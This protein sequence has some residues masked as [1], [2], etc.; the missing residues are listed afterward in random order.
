MGGFIDVEQAGGGSNRGY[1]AEAADAGAPGVVVIQEW[2]GL[3]DQI[4]GT[5]DR[6]AA[7]GYNALAPD[8]YGGE[9]AAYH[10][11]AAA[12]AAMNALD[13]MAATDQAVAGAARR[14]AANGAKVGLTGFCLGG[15]VT[16]LGAI[17]VPG[18]AAAV[19]FYGLPSPEM[20]APGDIAIPFQA[21][22]AN[23][24]DWCTPAAVDAFDAGLGANAELYRYDAKH[25][26]MNEQQPSVH[27]A[28]AAQIAS[29]RMLAFWR[30]HLT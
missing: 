12:E 9:V 10:D 28:A 4:T 19:C 5:C 14:L 13:V 17:R 8:L 30:R 6:L 27:D 29:A 11:H 26:F 15:M 20:G 3:Q 21:H 2:R 23:Q 24:D 16:V 22:F 18:L 1:L 25:G 7:A